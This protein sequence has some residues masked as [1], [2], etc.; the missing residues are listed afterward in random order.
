MSTI[1][2]VHGTG[3][4]GPEEGTKWWQ[5]GSAFE[6]HLRQLIAAEDGEFKYQPVT[7]DGN[8]CE[9]PRRTAAKKLA[10]EIAKLEQKKEAY[11]VIGHSHGGSIIANMV[12]DNF[13]P[14]NL[15]YLSQVI[16]IGTPYLTFRRRSL[17]SSLGLFGK[18]M[19]VFITWVC[20]LAAISTIIYSLKTAPYNGLRDALGLFAVGAFFFIPLLLF[21]IVTRLAKKTRFRRYAKRI[22]QDC[23]HFLAPRWICLFDRNDEAILGLSCVRRFNVRLFT[24]QFAVP[25]LSFAA[26]FVLPLLVSIA[27][28][29]SSIMTVVKNELGG[30]LTRFDIHKSF[31][32]GDFWSNLLYLLALSSVYA[33][34]Y[35]LE[36]AGIHFPQ[37]FLESGPWV[38]LSSIIAALLFVSLLSFLV[39]V[40]VRGMSIGISALLS[41]V[42][43]LFTWNAIRRLIFGSGLA[44][45][46]AVDA[47]AYPVWVPSGNNPIPQVLSDELT[48]FVNQETIKSLPKLRKAVYELAFSI[49]AGKPESFIQD[50]LSWNE[51]LHTS[52]FNIPH[53][54]MLVAFAIS[55]AKGFHARQPFKDASE[56]KVVAQ[57]FDE[58]RKNPAP[59]VRQTATSV[60]GVCS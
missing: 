35:P 23:R 32:I 18:S 17:F 9:S 37:K 2:T 16:T 31:S 3:S 20:S 54:R 30:L 58:I 42:L 14:S 38:G 15:I 59:L 60:E 8:N 48:S 19:F 36:L 47:F 45:E 26:F 5:K 10:V 43:D 11:I 29:S 49:V 33:V 41:R 25:A 46:T 1:L 53:F 57:W 4:S 50:Y 13:E 55:M 12:Q 52:Y 21:V 34:F 44:G 28:A 22:Q 24:K 40:V 27:A 39:T 7:W 51:L 56:F 6:A